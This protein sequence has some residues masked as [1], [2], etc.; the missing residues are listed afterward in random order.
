MV[1]AKPFSWWD[2]SFSILNT[3]T[4]LTSYLVRWWTHKASANSKGC[5]S[6]SFKTLSWPFFPQ[7]VC[8]PSNPQISFHQAFIFLNTFLELGHLFSRQNLSKKIY[9]SMGLMFLVDLE[10]IFLFIM[11]GPR[12]HVNLWFSMSHL[13]ACAW[14][15]D[16]AH[17]RLCHLT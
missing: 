2:P 13:L 4:L 6:C 17:C 5:L 3:S 12:S 1:W 15:F 11:Y 8:R 10:V 9:V 16:K 7:D 14:I